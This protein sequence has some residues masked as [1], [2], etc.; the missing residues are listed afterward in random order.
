ME[1]VEWVAGLDKDAASASFKAYDIRGIAGDP[2][3]PEFAYRLGRAVATFLDCDALAVARDIRDSGPALHAEFVR[4]LMD[5]GI[6]VHDL[7]I[8]PTGALYHA[9]VTLPVD[10]GI[11]I[12]ASHNPPEYNG[13][14]MCR[15]SSAMAGQE[16]Q[17]LL[18][19]FL[20]GEFR[21]G[22]GEHI[23]VEDFK[24]QYYADIIASTGLPARPV[25]VVV[26]SGNAVPGPF[27]VDILKMLG[28]DET[29]IL[30]EW[31]N[32]FPIHPPDPTRPAN[33]ELLGTKVREVGA[34]FGIG[35]DGDGDRM[36]MVDENGDFIHP[37]RIL[38]LF[39]ADIL[40]RVGEDASEAARTIFYDVK[41]SIALEETIAANGGIPHMMRT[42]HSFQ[43]LALKN[44]PET[45]L[46][47]EMSGHFFFNDK[48][49][50]F[51]DTLYCTARMLEL[52]GRDR[53]PSEGG[54]SF[55][56]RLSCIPT[57]PSTGEAKVPL[58]GERK[59]TM[60]FVEEVFSD[61]EMVTVDGVRVR[62]SGG[63][64]DAGWKGWFLCR[65]SNTEPILVMRAEATSAAGLVE[66]RSLV[67][68]KIGAR[69]DLAK[70]DDA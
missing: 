39:A 58:T 63:E 6:A 29:C 28:A 53:S 42:G 36:G 41:C 8:M 1:R 13:F 59:E 7:G 15:G 47:G 17:D 60:R 16:L 35:V 3:T 67:H 23:L 61:Y 9:T 32:S 38:A 25:K 70:F 33:M 54:V 44:S 37:D 62:L 27:M 50:G 46:A 4:G 40:S 65:P 57:Y 43:K 22:S 24:H 66:I 2:L 49:P 10:G 51:D 20:K 31:D 12:T 21:V 52:V 30:C 19:V 56:E 68:E 11:V 14:K 45:P 26:D 5:S 55:S 48:W 34:E 69:I 64:G 18:A